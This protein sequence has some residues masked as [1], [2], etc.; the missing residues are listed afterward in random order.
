[1]KTLVVVDLQKGF[2]RNGCQDTLN[3]IEKAAQSSYF[4]HIIATR[5]LNHPDSHFE[6]YLGWRGLSKV[7]EQIIAS[8]IVIKKA[9]IV[10]D[11]DSYSFLNTSFL[12]L[13]QNCAYGKL[14]LAGADTDACILKSAFD[15]FEMGLDFCVI[16]DCCFSSG[17]KTMHDYAIQIMKRSLGLKQ[18]CCLDELNI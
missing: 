16:E 7:E 13:L 4:D 2:L 10:F 3:K 14:F 1:M 6:K 9:Q 18:V 11:K 15:C 5:F 17:G 8:D 12:N